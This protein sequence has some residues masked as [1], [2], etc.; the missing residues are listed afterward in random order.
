[1]RRWSAQDVENFHPGMVATITDSRTTF[2][3]GTSINFRP[4][5]IP[6]RR[7]SPQT[8]T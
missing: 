1:M 7:S 2:P 4:V 3:N 5:T 6:F 8:E